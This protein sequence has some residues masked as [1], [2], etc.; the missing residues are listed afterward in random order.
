MAQDIL[1]KLIITALLMVFVLPAGH[2]TYAGNFGPPEPI[3]NKGKASLG[4]GYFHLSE[5]LNPSGVLDSRN[6]SFIRQHEIQRNQQYLQAGYGLIEN[7]EAYL[8]VGGSDLKIDNAFPLAARNGSSDIFKN[9]FSPFGTFGVKG[10]L[11][12]GSYFG[13]GPFFQASL[14]P[15]YQDKTRYRGIDPACEAHQPIICGPLFITDR[16]DELKVKN[17]WDVNLGIGLQTKVYGVTLYGGPFA[18]WTGYKAR[19]NIKSTEGNS[20]FD[21]T[22]YREK[23]NFGGFV[24]LRAPLPWVEGVHAEVEGQFKNKASFGISLHYS[25]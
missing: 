23:N 19:F 14:F 20:L 7:W 11:Y 24:G 22:H 21:K 8:R 12:D 25:F 6:K 18:Y 15:S 5:I 17:P 9:S 13:I 10:L 16:S 1:K 4:V 2:V 3:T